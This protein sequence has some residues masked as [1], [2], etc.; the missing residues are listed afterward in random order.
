MFVKTGAEG[1]F[2]AALPEQGLGIALKCD[3][4]ASARRRGDDGGGDRALLS[5]L[6]DAERAALD[7]FLR[8]T[9]RNWNGIEV[10]ALRPADAAAGVHEH[11][12][13]A[14]AADASRL[15]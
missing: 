2:C 9:L 5:T 8:P 14:V 6:T 13:H 10:G 1:V 3:D 12:A 7:R 11:L 4:G 15:A